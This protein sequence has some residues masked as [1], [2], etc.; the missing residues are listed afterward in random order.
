MPLREEEQE[1]PDY[2]IDEFNEINPFCDEL[3]PDDALTPPLSS[4][5][6]PGT[7]KKQLPPSLG[8]TP[9]SVKEPPPPYH[10]F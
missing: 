8:L 2:T 7:L 1:G 6:L 4:E 5:P 3:R 10:A 9:E